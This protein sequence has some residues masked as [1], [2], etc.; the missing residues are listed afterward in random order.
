MKITRNEKDSIM[1]PVSEQ[2]HTACDQ[3]MGGGDTA[4]VQLMQDTEGMYLEFIPV[5]AEDLEDEF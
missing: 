1:R 4:V 2:D 3:L 5:K